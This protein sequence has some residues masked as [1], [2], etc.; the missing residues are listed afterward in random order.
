MQVI[1]TTWNF[2]CQLSRRLIIMFYI[3]DAVINTERE[4]SNKCSERDKGKANFGL[5][6]HV[7]EDKILMIQSVSSAA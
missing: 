6:S 7:L 5:I 4:S 3:L 1:S 2:Q